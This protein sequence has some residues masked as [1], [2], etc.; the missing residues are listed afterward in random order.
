MFFGRLILFTN[1]REKEELPVTRE[2]TPMKTQ[3]MKQIRSSAE[4]VIYIHEYTHTY[5]YK[6]IYVYMLMGILLESAGT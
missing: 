3:N 6:Y 2:K 1:R 5:I 4:T